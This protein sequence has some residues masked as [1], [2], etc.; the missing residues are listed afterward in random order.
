M[1]YDHLKFARKFIFVAM[2]LI[3]LAICA[4][5]LAFNMRAEELT[6]S[7]IHQQARSLFNQMILVRRWV[8][9]HGG[10]YVQVRPGVDPNPYLTKLAGLKVNIVDQ[11]GTLYTLRNPGTATREIS[12]LSSSAEGYS[13]HIASLKPVNPVTNTPDPFERKALLQFEQG[14]K[15]FFEIEERQD[16]PVYRY[17]APL[18]YESTCNRCHSNQGY[19]NGDIRGGISVTIPMRDVTLKMYKNRIMIIGSAIVVLSLL[20]GTL[21]FISRRF[22]R[23]LEETQQKLVDMAVTD[24]LTGL[25]NRRSGLMRIEKELSRQQRTGLPACCLLLDLDYFKKIN[26]GF[27]HQTGDEVLVNFARIIEDSLRKHDIICRY[28]GEE[29]LILLP[30]SSLKAA[31]ATAEKI[32]AKTAESRLEFDGRP[33]QFTTSIGIAQMLPN[34]TAKEMI[35]RADQALYMAKHKGRNCF[36]AAE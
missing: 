23:A 22:L 20:L 34:E 5:F 9:S 1:A 29:F 12:Q 6:V 30:D 7:V 18:Y 16:G 27:G 14:K 11:S 21:W 32:C 10:V 4:I 25:P 13:Y 2:V 28:G 19:A 31:I 3:T 24:I 33:L 17:M 26:D 15:E 36:V 35:A 8:T